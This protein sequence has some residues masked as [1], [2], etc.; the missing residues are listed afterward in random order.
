M[1]NGLLTN[2][3]SKKQ[4][5]GPGSSSL[6]ME[7]GDFHRK[8]NGEAFALNKQSPLT[9]PGSWVPMSAFLN[10]RACTRV[11]PYQTFSLRTSQLSH[12]CRSSML[13]L[14]NS[15]WHDTGVRGMA[16]TSEANKEK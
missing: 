5:S 11:M 8:V 1:N 3:L 16:T 10:R 9:N 4:G 14:G 6:Y 13:S 15:R 2:K 7:A 12:G